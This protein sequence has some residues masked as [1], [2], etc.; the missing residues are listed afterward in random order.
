MAEID[1]RGFVIIDDADFAADHLRE[2]DRGGVAD[3]EVPRGPHQRRRVIGHAGDA[4]L[5]FGAGDQ[6]AVVRSDHGGVERAFELLRVLLLGEIAPRQREL[7]VGNEPGVARLEHHGEPALLPLRAPPQLEEGVAALRRAD[8]DSPALAVGECG[9][10]DLRPHARI[11]VG[12]FVEHDAVEIDAAHGIG[13]VGA[14]EPHLAAFGIIDPQLALV[15]GGAVPAQRRHPRTQVVPRHR[16][17]LPQERRQIGEARPLQ[18][19]FQRL[20]LQLVHARDGLAGAA[21]GHD[22]GETLGPGM[23]RSELRARAVVDLELQ[24]RTFGRTRLL[25]R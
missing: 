11:H 20:L 25:P 5:G 7:A 14:V 23:E 21:V 10:D 1:A 2:P 24:C 16:L 19:A 13:I 3:A 17:R 4:A 15:H 18:L 12:V 6:L 22:A 8:E 9:A